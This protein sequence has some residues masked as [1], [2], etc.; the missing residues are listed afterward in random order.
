MKKII[1][2]SVSFTS[3]AGLV[4]LLALSAGTTGCLFPTTGSG[5]NAVTTLD[6]N[7]LAQV[8]AVVEPLLSSVI[9]RVIANS[10]QHSAEIASYVGAIG[11]VCCQMTANNNFTP[12][13]LVDALEKATAGLQLGVDQDIIDAKNAVVAIYKIAYADQLTVSLGNGV[14]PRAVLG[15]LCDSVNQALSD[16]GLPSTKTPNRSPVRLAPYT[17]KA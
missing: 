15:T 5:T 14:W 3:L 9:R 6:T 17:H 2:I 4:A 8:Q 7:K 10:P 12:T 13:Y 11:S 16:S 1:A